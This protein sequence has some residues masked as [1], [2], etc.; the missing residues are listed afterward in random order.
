MSDCPNP[1]H[2][3]ITRPEVL[4]ARIGS[5]F[6]KIPEWFRCDVVVPVVITRF[7]LLLV[8]WLGFRFLP[9][10][11]VFPSAWEIGPD[12]N[13]HAVVDHISPTSHPWVNMLSRWDAGWYVEIARDGYR[14]EPGSPSNAA[15]FPLYPVLIRV[16]HALL[17]LPTDDYWWLVTAIALSN[18][19]LI[20]LTYF[21]ALLAMDFDETLVS[22]AITYL[23]IF[24]TTFFFSGVYSESLFL[25][26]TVAAFYYARTNRWLLACILAALATLTRSQGMILA[27]PLL[28]E[29]L[30]ERNFRLRKVG[31]NITAF[32][33][34]P[35]A[36]LAFALFLKLK[37]GNWTVMF[38]VQSIWGR[39][40]M[41]PWH[42]LA[43]FLRHAPPLSPEHHDK[44]DFGF[45][46]LLLGAAVAGLR[47]LRI[48]YSAYIWTAVVFFSCWGMLGSIPRFDLVIFPLFVVLALIGARFR[49]FHL[50]YVVASTMLA[51]LFMLMHSQWNWVA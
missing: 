8:G 33:L 18:A 2:L 30:G 41:W 17:F 20:G 43:W 4:K 28:I 39:H 9:L 16:I 14:Y 36:L 44:L 26:L 50:G 13:N 35:A 51:A 21:R 10:P 6:S 15:F 11:V 27:L 1:R 49:A 34:I 38:D 25:A 22:R 5:A 42:P 45:L 37:F 31:W 32:A 23:L 12:G 48:S 3:L 24:P 46:L 19:L 29:Y 7:A 40:L 47:R